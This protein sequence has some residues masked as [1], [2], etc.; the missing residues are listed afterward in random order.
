MYLLDSEN[1]P[2]VNKPLVINKHSR[3]KDYDLWN[4]KG[5]ALCLIMYLFSIEPPFYAGL[6][7]ACRNKEEESLESLGPFAC[8]IFWILSNAER[9]R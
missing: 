2:D 4:P 9:E 7:K 5:R 8:A 1:Y 6:N 3:K